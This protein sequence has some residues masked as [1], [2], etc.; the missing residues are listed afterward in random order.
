MRGKVIY[1]LTYLIAMGITPAHAGKSFRTTIR[2]EFCQDHP[3]TCGEKFVLCLHRNQMLGSPPHMRGKG[4]QGLFV[5]L[6]QRITPAHA[7]KSLRGM[8]SGR[9]LI[10]SPPHMRGKGISS[11]YLDGEKRITPAHAGKSSCIVASFN[12]SEDHPRTCGEKACRGIALN[13]VFG[14]PPHMRGKVTLNRFF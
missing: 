8:E 12:L 6:F 13:A 2:A 10:G 14:S 9:V 11:A 1:R 5:F 4:Q 3:R 7:G